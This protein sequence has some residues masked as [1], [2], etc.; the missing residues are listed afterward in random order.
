MSSENVQ[1]WLEDGERL[2][3]SFAAELELIR[4]RFEQLELARQAL[5]AELISKETQFMRMCAILDMADSAEEEAIA[6]QFEAEARGAA[7]SHEAQHGFATKAGG[8]HVKPSSRAD[9]HPNA[10]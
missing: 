7:E 2:R 3:D 10:A 1:N 8:P 4:E 9:W 5:E 6:Q